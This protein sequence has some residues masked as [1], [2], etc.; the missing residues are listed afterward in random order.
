VTLDGNI[1]A[2]GGKIGGWNITDSTLYGGNVVI[3]SAGNMRCT[4][5]ND[6]RWALTNDGL[7]RAKQ[8]YIAGWHIDEESIWNDSGTTLNTN[9]NNGHY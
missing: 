9:L 1:Y 4:I 2:S 7:I 6:L 3:D 8:G 5:S